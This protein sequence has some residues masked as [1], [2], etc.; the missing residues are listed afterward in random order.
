MLVQVRV[1]P[2]AKK[3]SVTKTGEDIL[4]VKV[5]EKAVGDRANKRL[6]EIL[7]K[8]L[9]VPKSRIRIV[10]GLRSR[11]KMIEVILENPADKRN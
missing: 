3:A 6:L 9:D 11:D 7:S 2:N 1:T 4:E 8:H 5:D 10:R